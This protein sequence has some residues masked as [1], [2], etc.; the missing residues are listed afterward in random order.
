M[1]HV[2]IGHILPMDCDTLSN[3]AKRGLISTLPPYMLG[4]D[5][6]L[7]HLKGI[8]TWLRGRGTGPFI[9]PRY[10]A[11]YVEEAKAYVEERMGRPGEMVQ[12][13]SSRQISHIPDALYMV[14][15]SSHSS[16]VFVSPD[17]YHLC[18]SSSSSSTA[19]CYEDMPES[20]NAHTQLPIIEDRVLLLMRQREQDLKALGICLR[21]LVLASNRCEV[22]K[23][24]QLRVVREFGLPDAASDVLHSSNFPYTQDNADDQATYVSPSEVGSLSIPPPPRPMTSHCSNASAIVSDKDPYSYASEMRLELQTSCA[25]SVR[26]PTEP[27]LTHFDIESQVSLKRCYSVKKSYSFP[28]FF[29]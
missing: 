9:R 10:F 7:P 11:S 2:R 13:R 19:N 8:S 5:T 18:L 12:N 4:E 21:A 6:G 17:H 26:T 23:M 28:F 27:C 22:T 16:E 20:G 24:I 14:D 25:S 29:C 1:C 3:A 15:K